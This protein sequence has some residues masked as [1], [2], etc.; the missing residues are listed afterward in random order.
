MQPKP[1]NPAGIAAL[2]STI[3]MLCMCSATLGWITD[4]NPD[5]RMTFWEDLFDNGKLDQLHTCAQVP[6]SALPAGCATM[7][8]LSPYVSPFSGPFDLSV[9]PL[10]EAA[11]Y[12]FVVTYPDGTQVVYQ[13]SS[14]DVT[15][16]TDD[17]P[18]GIYSVKVN[19]L[20]AAGNIICFTS[21][22]FSRPIPSYKQSCTLAFIA[23]AGNSMLPASGPVEFSWTSQPDAS[24][25]ILDFTLPNGNHGALDPTTDTFKTVFMEAFTPGGSYIV[26]VMA[27]DANA[28]TICQDTMTFTKPEAW[29]P[30]K[31]A[32]KPPDEPQSD[33]PLIPILPFP[34][35]FEPTEP[36]R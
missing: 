29:T 9:T 31:N 33:S 22:N 3:L 35:V 32:P 36:P 19:V 7:E 17:L 16:M 1:S 14:P 5:E 12:E 13:S 18:P 28:Q 11:S 34:P 4:C 25:Y 2:I 10:P 27:L 8:W 26:T 30:T 6:I 15:V 20:D 24:S 23:P 21:G